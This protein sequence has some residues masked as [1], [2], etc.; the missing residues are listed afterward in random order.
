[1]WQG[2]APVAAVRHSLG[3]AEDS[4]ARVLFVGADESDGGLPQ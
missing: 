4:D 3:F 1:M 2:I